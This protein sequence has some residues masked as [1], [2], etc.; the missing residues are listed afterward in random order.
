MPFCP[1]CRYEYRPEI[2]VCPDC[3]EKLVAEL[4]PEPVGQE[5]VCIA[6]YAYQSDAQTA[7]MNLQRNGIRAVLSNEVMSALSPDVTF[8][9]GGIHLLV[10]ESN[11]DRA[12]KILE[13]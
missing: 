3:G 11:A 9:D 1:K 5:L 6:N 4:P 7:K 12:R 13:G 2:K 10:H 8:A